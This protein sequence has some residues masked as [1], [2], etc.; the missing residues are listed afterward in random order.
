MKKRAN[1]EGMIRQRK[2]GR[3]EGRI[4]IG[5]KEDR[6]PMYRSVYARTLEELMIKHQNQINVHRGTALTEKS[7]ITLAQWLEQW[8]E[9]YMRDNVGENTFRSYSWIIHNRIVPHLG[10]R[11][12]SYI[13][14]AD[15][16]KMYNYL[17]DNGRKEEHFEYDFHLSGNSVRN[18]HNLLHQAMEAAKHERIIA[19]NPTIGAV[20]PEITYKQKWIFNDEQLE[21]FLKEIKKEPDW[22]AFFYTAITTGLR[23]GELCGLQWNDINEST[24]QLSV[25]RSVG[26]GR[27]VG[28]QE[29]TTK[30][31]AGLRTFVLPQS[32]F[33][34][35]ME[36]K[37]EIYSK[38]IFPDPKNKELPVSPQCAYKKLKTILRN[39]DLPDIRFH[40]LRHTFATHAL[41]SG[42]DVKTLAQILGH[43]NPSFTLDTYTHVT[44]DMH[45]AAANIVGDFLEQVMTI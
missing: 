19:R 2:D 41:S 11:K 45:R 30:T 16:Q 26:H 18:T 42:V 32:T 35:L 40:D 1:G 28:N 13:T 7:K 17:L 34:L 9:R 31:D 37:K 4:V 3:W 10:S 5:Y 29:Q 43:T 39:G 23:R 22:Y 33:N 44:T 8:L 6:T 12:I 21:S 38:W 25:K 14:T 15:V 24:G 36:R 27:N 20:L